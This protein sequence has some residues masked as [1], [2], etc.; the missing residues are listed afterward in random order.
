LTTYSSTTY[1]LVELITVQLPAPTLSASYLLP[2]EERITVIW[3]GNGVAGQCFWHVLRAVEIS[4]ETLKHY[5]ALL[6][7]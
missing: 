7:P 6:T 3:V 4:R 5:S 1:L 2:S